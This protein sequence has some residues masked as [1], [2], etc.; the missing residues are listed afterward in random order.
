MST[1]RTTNGRTV[2]SRSLARTRVALPHRCNTGACAALREEGPTR[3]PR[4]AHL[5][6]SC[7]LH[8]AFVRC[9][10]L[11]WRSLAPTQRLI[12]QLALVVAAC[13]AIGGLLAPF[14][15]TT[16]KRSRRASRHSGDGHAT[17]TWSA[18]LLAELIATLVG[19]RRRDRAE[20][21]ARSVAASA[22]RDRG[23]RPGSAAKAAGKHARLPTAEDVD[24]TPKAEDV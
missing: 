5:L 10:S 23:T 16:R 13:C 17:S 7:I 4:I 22:R 18:A 2:R 19:G 24:A 12:L 9:S 8:D 6:T 1:E 11:R 21:E 15:S 3:D 14:I 20:R